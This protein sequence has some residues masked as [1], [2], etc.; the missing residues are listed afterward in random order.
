MQNKYNRM[1]T[2]VKIIRARK[3]IPLSKE[4]YQA[5]KRFRKEFQTEV[6]CAVKI[7]IDRAVLNRILLVGSGSAESVGKIQK[8]L[9]KY[10]SKSN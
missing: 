7:G 1:D 9:L 2:Q 10:G 6:D 5:L 4:D 8:A 3:S